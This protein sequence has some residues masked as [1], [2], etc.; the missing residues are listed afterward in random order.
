MKVIY[1]CEVCG[2]EYNKPDEACSCERNHYNIRFWDDKFN[3]LP[4]NDK[5]TMERAYYVYVADQMAIDYVRELCDK[6]YNSIYPFESN[7]TPGL[8][9]WE[10]P[11]TWLHVADEMDR[12]IAICD[13]CGVQL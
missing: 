9:Y 3:P 8:Y 7:A 10:R 1:K 6:Y 12:L 4:I 13:A 5:N 2:R 11:Y